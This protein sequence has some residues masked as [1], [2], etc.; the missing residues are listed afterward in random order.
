MSRGS[1]TF[2]AAGDVGP[3]VKLTMLALNHL[4]VLLSHLFH[5]VPKIPGFP[6]ESCSDERLSTLA[7]SVGLLSNSRLP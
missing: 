6:Y 3:R 2:G 1:V 4:E 5:M 7:E